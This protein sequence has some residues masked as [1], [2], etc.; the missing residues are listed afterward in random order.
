MSD[1]RHVIGKFD[2][3]LDL[4]VHLWA[5]GEVLSD[6]LWKAPIG[7]HPW[8]EEEQAITEYPLEFLFANN[9]LY[10]GM[11]SGYIEKVD[12]KTGESLARYGQRKFLDQGEA[13]PTKIRGL[14]LFNGKVHDAS[15]AGLFVTESGEEVDD[16]QVGSVEVYDGRLLIVPHGANPKQLEGRDYN[17]PRVSESKNRRT[18]TLAPSLYRFYDSVRESKAGDLIDA[19][20]KEVIM[21][22]VR[23]FDGSGMSP[24]KH[25]IVGNKVYMHHGNYPGER[26]TIRS[27][28]TGEITDVIHLI[29]TGGFVNQ[30]GLVYDIRVCP[31]SSLSGLHERTTRILRSNEDYNAPSGSLFDKPESEHFS[32]I[33]SAGIDGLLIG[34]FNK[35]QNKTKVISHL[36][37][38]KPLL[39]SDS[40]LFLCGL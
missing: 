23:P 30:E 11:D 35:E 9:H 26:I 31:P 40:R 10:M 7:E 38:G 32:G 39:E 28:P 33:A 25:V 2:G 12:V 18:I 13:K 36:N 24:G 3:K 6:P 4:T 8:K 37:P 16:R 20:S 27:F 29:T 17:S 34:L 5:P 15:Y 1:L 21:E 19:I 22:C 14:V